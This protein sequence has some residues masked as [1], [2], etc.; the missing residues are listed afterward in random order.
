MLAA[1]SVAAVGATLLVG[2]AVGGGDRVAEQPGS[3]ANTAEESA[4]PELP[5]VSSQATRPNVVVVMTDDQSLQTM[6]VMRRTQRIIGDHGATFS[7]SLVSYPLC[8][9][10]RTTFLTGQF[11][12]NHGVQGNSP[13]GDGGGYLNLVQPGRTL[14]AWL[15]ASGYRTAHVGKWANAPGP[16]SPAGWDRLWMTFDGTT[17]YYG[18]RAGRPD[19]KSRSLGNETRDYHT[20][21][22]TRLATRFIRAEGARP[23]EQ[24]FFLSV[25]YLAPHD[26]FGRDDEASRRCAGETAAGD[27]NH[28][29]A[30]PAPRHRSAFSN[31]PLPRPPS[32]NEEDVTDKPAAVR[33]ARLSPG[34]VARIERRYRCELASLLSVD[35]G[36]QRIWTALGETG[37]ADQTVFVFTSDHGKLHGEHR[38]G[39]R[40]NRPYEE[41]IRVPLMI[42][43]PGVPDGITL[44]D[45]VVNADLAP[46]ILD[47]AQA[48]PEG[49]LAREIDGSSLVPLLEGG[50]D[51]SDRAIPIE[52]RLRTELAGGGY[53][54]L[55]YVGVRTAR[56]SYTEY[57][58]QAVASESEGAEVAIGEGELVGRELYDLEA[59]PYQLRNLGRDEEAYVGTR[60]ALAAVLNR[61]RQCAGSACDIRAQIPNP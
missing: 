19:G 41:A 14:P 21:A 23:D 59:D 47:L 29:G 15:Q 38:H 32:F 7:Q 46:T 17:S 49:G 18:Y 40:K 43:G 26:G 44:N 10:S 4:K 6:R 39:V 36:V 57:Y 55:S 42:R 48:Q 45:P 3:E 24:P 2:C 33:E 28:L 51:W 56:Y 12:H 16:H 52:G 61:L 34:V 30:V 53:E 9:P 25:A 20:D 8:C 1:L 54:V 50:V 37:A 22:V 11:A 27:P 35:E 58:R 5:L 60:P 31:T 13:S